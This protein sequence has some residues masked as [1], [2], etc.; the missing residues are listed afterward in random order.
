M[1]KLKINLIIVLSIV[2]ILSGC[3]SW[4][5]TNKGA[6]IGTTVGGGVI[7]STGKSSGNGYMG[8]IPGA[9]VGGPVG[10]IIGHKMDVQVEEMKKTVPDAKIERL[11]EGIVL[12]FNSNILFGFDKSL[13]AFDSKSNLDKLFIVL[14]KY[15]DT[16]IELQGYTDNKGSDIYNQ[17]LS[18]KRAKTVSGYLIAKG[19]NASR[20][21]VKGY[22]E[23]MPKYDNKK[24]AGRNQ[25][26]RVEFLITANVEMRAEAEKEAINK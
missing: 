16:N 3:T 19:I 17:E 22:G 1:N 24:A 9:T 5:K 2:T 7:A 12:E 13:L 10:K 11:G 20:I 6:D 21:T 18:E 23:T 25:N 8:A 15:N 26:R 4:N 14:N